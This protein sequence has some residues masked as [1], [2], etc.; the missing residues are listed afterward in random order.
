MYGMCDVNIRLPQAI[1]DVISSVGI[2][3]A[4]ADIIGYRAPV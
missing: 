4:T 3:T 1:N 2:G